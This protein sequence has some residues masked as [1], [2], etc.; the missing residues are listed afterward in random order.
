MR[1]DTHV[2]VLV[3]FLPNVVHG[4]DSFAS[5]R[6]WP[7]PALCLPCTWHFARIELVR[8]I[9]RKVLFE[10]AS[11]HEDAKT[12]LQVWLDAAKA[13]RWNSLEDIRRSFPA[14]DLVGPL[15]IFNIKGNS[16]RLIVRMMFGRQKPLSKNS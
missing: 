8:V 16:Y 2:G 12:A 5:S 10:R 1:D 15:A 13:A 6:N 3:E 4:W 7:F 11:R 14:T 9:S